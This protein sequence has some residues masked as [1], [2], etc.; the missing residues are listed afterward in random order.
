MATSDDKS[1]EQKPEKKIVKTVD[2]VINTL[3]SKGNM[4]NMHGERVPVGGSLELPIA[5]CEKLVAAGKARYLNKA[6][7]GSG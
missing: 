3:G 6:E 4:T 5:L 7:R 1:T 2:T